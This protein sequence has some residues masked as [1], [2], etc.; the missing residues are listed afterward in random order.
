VSV[1][2]WLPLPSVVIATV[3]PVPPIT[4]LVVPATESWSPLPAKLP[5]TFTVAL[6][7]DSVRQ[8]GRLDV[9]DHAVNDPGHR[10]R[11]RALGGKRGNHVAAEGRVLRFMS[12]AAKLCLERFGQR[13]RDPALAADRFGHDLDAA[14][15]AT[16]SM[17]LAAKG[18]RCGT[19]LGQSVAED[20]QAITVVR[21]AGSEGDDVEQRRW[22]IGAAARTEDQ[23]RAE[24]SS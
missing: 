5:L 23:Q 10:W 8:R 17:Q 13:R 15:I 11:A 24:Q 21:F 6:A 7:R 20:F 14:R 18:Q 4:P 3:M 19:A 1:S 9:E 16:R 22:R 12:R 2:V